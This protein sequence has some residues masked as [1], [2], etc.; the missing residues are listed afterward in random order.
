[1]RHYY[2]L[3][4]FFFRYLKWLTL[5]G[6]LLAAVL[7]LGWLW[8]YARQPQAAYATYQN[9][10]YDPQRWFSLSTLFA[11]AFALLCLFLSVWLYASFQ[12]KRRPLYTLLTLP[13]PRAALPLALFT[14]VLISLALFFLCE[15]GVLFAGYHLWAH[16]TPAATQAFLAQIQAADPALYEMLHASA[17]YPFV[18]NDLYLAFVHSP[19]GYLVLPPT[20]SYLLYPLGLVSLIAALCALDLFTRNSLSSSALLLALLC[21]RQA[22]LSEHAPGVGV[23][24]LCAALVV[25]TGAIY[26]AYKRP[27]V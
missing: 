3:T 2:K 11:L 1:M 21:S 6:A 20:L 15:C 25:L 19:V 16:Q 9:M 7:Q 23:L 12:G 14:A 26:Q 10:V 18:N 24:M 22:V 17:A 5:A 8:H 27:A 13:G 4:C